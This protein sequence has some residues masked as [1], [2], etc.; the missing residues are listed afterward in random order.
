MAVQYQLRPPYVGSYGGGSIAVGKYATTFDVGAA[1]A[2]GG[3]TITAADQDLIRALDAYAPLFRSGTTADPISDAFDLRLVSVSGGNGLT[4]TAPVF[5]VRRNGDS[6]A[7]WQVLANGNMLQG[8]GTLAPHAFTSGSSGHAVRVADHGAVADGAAFSG[9]SMTSGSA[10]LTASGFSPSDVGKTIMVLGAGASGGTLSSTIASYTSATQVT[11]TN[12]ASTSVSGADGNYA[13]DSAQA[14]QDAIDELISLGGGGE[15]WF[16]QGTYGLSFTPDLPTGVTGITARGVGRSTRLLRL[17]NITLWDVS[18]TSSFRRTGCKL[19][20]LR[21]DGGGVPEWNAPLHRLD[22]TSRC[23]AVRV[24]WVHAFGSGISGR[25][26]WDTYFL[27]SNCTDCG[28][29][30]GVNPAVLMDAVD[31]DGGDATNSVYFDHMVIESW[32]TGALWAKGTTAAPIESVQAGILKIERVGSVGPAWGPAVN[33]E[34][35]QDSGW[36]YA[37]LTTSGN[38]AS[39]QTAPYASSLRLMGCDGIQ[40]GRTDAYIANVL[41][42][43]VGEMIHFDGSTA[44]NNAVHLGDWF[45]RSGSGDGTN[46]PATVIRYDGTNNKIS[47]GII[48]WNSNFWSVPTETGSPTTLVIP[49]VIPSVAEPITDASFPSGGVAD[50]MA[51]R[52][53]AS[54][55]IFVRAGGSWIDTGGTGYP[56]TSEPFLLDNKNRSSMSR[57]QATSDLTATS[58]AVYLDMVPYQ[59]GDRINPML[60]V[61]GGTGF[62]FGATAPA[63]FTG[64]YSIGG[65]PSVA[66]LIAQSA[67]MAAA[68]ATPASVTATPSAS[69]G[70]FTAATYFY[71]VSALFPWGESAV[72]SEVSAV[73][74]A[75]GSVAL[76]WGAVTGATGYRVYRGTAAGAESA[77]QVATGNSF[78]DTGSAGTAGTPPTLHTLPIGQAVQSTL[79]N[80]GAG[81]SLGV[82]TFTISTT[83]VY[84]HA[85]LV[86]QGTGGSMG[87]LRGAS[88]NFSLVDNTLAGWSRRAAVNADS[89]FTALP[90]SITLSGRSDSKV[91]FT[92]SRTQ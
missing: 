5:E 9:A 23:H 86:K 60:H 68:F 37:I 54:G 84:A 92:A 90:T 55:H 14:I 30:D 70:T 15:L 88:L 24:A 3:G 69:G 21:L 17:A 76:T 19:I 62:S 25:Q 2:A 50:G 29:T 6:Y 42:G 71:K 57:M 74:V 52:G 10:V 28:A 78:T 87:V 73:V 34:H 44:T 83:G 4:G 89:V 26:I 59:S 39:G 47:R 75:N 1:L 38:K 18:G 65:S 33:F 8:D 45:L 81:A 46:R 36:N 72:S 49:P 16:D 43:E 31:A 11:L 80:D 63:L 61:V 56:A 77:Y 82:S 41:G 58:G 40:L 66:T 91:R 48:K 20:D 32:R 85:I 79:V 27:E 35:V 13:S 64:L 51:A 22:Y 67:D 12:A 7:R 53:T